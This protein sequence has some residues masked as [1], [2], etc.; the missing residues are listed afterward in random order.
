MSAK[1]RSSEST[2]TKFLIIHGDKGG[3]GKSFVATALADFLSS[4]GDK[5]AIIDSDTQNPDVARMFDKSLSCAQ[6]NVRS[7]NGWMDVMDFVMKHPGHTIIM[8]TPAGIGEYMKND[9]IS[10][11]N[12]LREQDSPIEMELWWAMNI[13][14]DS[15]NLL[16][17]AFKSYG[18]FFARLRVVLNLHFANGD[19]SASGPFFLWNE[20]PLKARIEKE[21]GMTV[22][23]P[24]LHLRVV[25][26]LFAPKKC[27]PYSEAVDGVLGES[28]GLEH[29]ERWKLQQWLTEAANG[30]GPA[31]GAVEITSPATA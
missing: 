26:K 29:S 21:N 28:L 23:F 9:M 7:E 27:M 19:R 17:D 20:S 11:S 12:F 15:V 14:H 16:N 10:F 5:V 3:V 2:I 1:N 31:F 13:Q 22:F 4:R 8:N 6:I 18:Q 30:F 24:A 25:A